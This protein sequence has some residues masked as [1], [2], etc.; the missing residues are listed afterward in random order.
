MY[1]S[2]S[3]LTATQ[4]LQRPLAISHLCRGYRDCM[5]QALCVHCDM[6]LN[7]GNFLPGVIPLQLRR[8]RVLHALRVHDQERAAG[9]APQSLAGHANLIF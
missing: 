3:R 8:V 9:V 2:K 5:R 4:G 7:A 6:A 1:S